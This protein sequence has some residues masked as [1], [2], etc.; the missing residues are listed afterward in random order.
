VVCAK[1]NPV[2]LIVV[3]SM[4]AK[5][6]AVETVARFCESAA[7]EATDSHRRRKPLAAATGVVDLYV[8]E[9]S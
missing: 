9:R 7:T 4:R 1:L 3:L 6:R 5:S 2:P 8:K